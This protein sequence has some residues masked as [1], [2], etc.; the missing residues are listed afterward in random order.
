MLFHLRKR[1][2]FTTFLVFVLSFSLTACG[3]GSDADSGTASESE[4][5]SG[6]EVT[7]VSLATAGTGGAW[8]PI[9]GGMA[10]IVNEKS[11]G[12]EMSAEVTDGGIENI[13]LVNSGVNEFAFANTDVVYEGFNGLNHFEAEGEQNIS[14][15][16]YLYPSTFQA[17]VM[18]DSGIDSIADLKG[19]RVAVGPPASSSEV[20]GWIILEEYGITSNDINGQT[21]SFEEGA[22]ALRDGNVDALFVMSAHPNSQ[23]MDLAATHDIKLLPVDED[24]RVKVT[25]EYDYY[26]ESIIEAGVYE[27]QTDDI[28]TLSLGTTIVANADVPEE[29]A[30]E[31]TKSVYEN[32]EE[33]H[34]FHD[35]AKQISLEAAPNM[36]IPL[37]PGAKKYFEE[38]GMEV[39]E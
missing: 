10:N 29:V 18:E 3:S 21:I 15:M 16:F 11:N 30:Y 28:H 34:Q 9:G 7:R 8:Y 37:H 5:E 19:K 1:F 31:F 27:D 14:A 13:R 6:S 33:V 32:L 26:Q 35:V 25:D 2:L 12:V 38:K 36:P 23:V 20:M 4:S 24:V 17:V 22:T 39:G